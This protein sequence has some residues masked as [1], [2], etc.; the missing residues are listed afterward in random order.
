MPIFQL[1]INSV[2]FPD[3]S[4]AE[5]D[6]DGLLAVGGDLSP[7]RLLNAYANGIFPWFNEDDPILWWSPSERAV[8]KPSEHHLSRSTKKALKR[9]SWRIT[10]NRCFSQVLEHCA[11]VHGDTWITDDM[12]NAYQDLH[13]LGWAHSVEVWLDGELVGGL[14]GIAIY[15]F[16]FG[17]SM[18]SL[19]PNASK[20]A[21]MAL[22]KHLE[23]LNFTLLDCQLPT[24]HLSSMGARPVSRAYLL[25]S[26]RETTISHS[27]VSNW[28]TQWNTSDEL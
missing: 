12:I 2:E 11:S 28:D 13:E 21:F 25:E 10:T 8:L 24:E 27:P 5:S 26:L 18:F 23:Q 1:D 20:L 14:Y 3:P 19:Q 9:Q 16:F 6:P 15:P 17:E 4:L 7:Q 22:C